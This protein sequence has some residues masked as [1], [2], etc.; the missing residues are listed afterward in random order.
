MYT[1]LWGG[2]ASVEHVVILVFLVVRLVE[3]LHILF[4][5]ARPAPPVPGRGVR[6]AV[7]VV[8]L[9]VGRGLLGL[10]HRRRETFRAWSTGVKPVARGSDKSSD[11]QQDINYVSH[12][13]IQTPW[14][15]GAGS[16]WSYHGN[17]LIS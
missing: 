3:V 10:L 2:G 4:G 16:G 14:V 17:S 7:A 6:G 9:V 1:S 12:D 11:W 5:P 8:V 15:G 13:A